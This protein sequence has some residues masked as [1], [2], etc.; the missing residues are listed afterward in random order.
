MA[1]TLARCTFS[2]D[3]S[4]RK[5]LAGKAFSG[6]ASGRSPRTA[7][8]FWDAPSPNRTPLAACSAWAAGW[9]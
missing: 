5:L 8:R 4:A 2:A 6:I 1:Y 3:C 9:C 7:A